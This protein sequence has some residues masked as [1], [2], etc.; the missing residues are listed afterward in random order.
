MTDER[1]YPAEVMPEEETMPQNVED[2]RVAVVGHKIV[3]AEKTRVEGRWGPR[4]IFRIRLDNGYTVD[5][6]DTSDCCAFTELEAFLLN[7]ELVDHVITGVGTTDG[8]QTWHIYADLGD[9]LTLT[10]GWSEGNPYYYG[11]GFAIQVR[12]STDG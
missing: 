1:R 2:L 10:V 4:E 3:S 6:E 8:F 7:P 9:V 12:E 11:Y 5:L